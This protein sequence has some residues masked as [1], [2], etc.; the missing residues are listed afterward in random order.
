MDSGGHAAEVG[1]AAEVGINSG[2]SPSI[3]ITTI[4]P[5]T[6]LF[7]DSNKDYVEKVNETVDNHNKTQPTAQIKLMS[8]YCPIGNNVVLV[9]HDGKIA[10]VSNRD[11]YLDLKK[12]GFDD[13][14]MRFFESMKEPTKHTTQRNRTEQ[15]AHA[16]WSQPKEGIAAAKLPVEFTLPPSP[17]TSNAS[18]CWLRAATPEIREPRP[19][20]GNHK[21]NVGSSF[22]SDVIKQIIA[23]EKSYSD[24]KRLYFFDFCNLLS[25]DGIFVEP[26]DSISPDDY[27]HLLFSDHVVKTEDP[28][29]RLNLLKQMFKLIGKE[30][31][32]VITCNPAAS[33]K[34]EYKTIRD[35]FIQILRV[36]IPD[37]SDGHVKFCTRRISPTKIVPDKGFH[38]VEF[39]NK[40][41]TAGGSIKRRRMTSKKIKKTR[42]GRRTR[43]YT[44]NVRRNKYRK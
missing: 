27:A 44:R 15:A 34:E 20:G 43:K 16:L 33:V 22:T 2:Q 18:S 19:D 40:N 28:N 5:E 4:S 8:I 41:Q 42:Y 38:I 7:F 36:L 9:T 35:K 24:N 11:E 25:L 37:L 30:R 31:I 13:N 39:I 3:N 12:K 10:T 17:A 32:Y 26:N 1:Q 6:H 23:F 29:D 14:V 21:K